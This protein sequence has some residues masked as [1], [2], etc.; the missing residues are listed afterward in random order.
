MCRTTAIH[1]G[2]HLTSIVDPGV[3]IFLISA[4]SSSVRCTIH[5]GRNC[6]G[7]DAIRFEGTK[8]RSKSAGVAAAVTRELIYPP[9]LRLRS[10]L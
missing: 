9:T 6:Q 10:L 1:G 2:G 8:I 5:S 3:W 7:T 4:S